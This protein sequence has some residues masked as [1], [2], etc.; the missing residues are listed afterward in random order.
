VLATC[1]LLCSPP[2]FDRLRALRATCTVYC[3][4][5]EIEIEIL[6]ILHSN[7]L[8]GQLT[9]HER[10]TT[11]QGDEMRSINFLEKLTANRRAARNYDAG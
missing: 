7:A 2:V 8:T 5:T 9:R 6:V 4:Q 11:G 3:V 1:C 10:E